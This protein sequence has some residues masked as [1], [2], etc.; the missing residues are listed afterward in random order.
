MKIPIIE[1]FISIQ[2]EGDNIGHLTYFI[3]FPHCDLSCIW[4]DTTYASK[5]SETEIKE[6]DVKEIV[7][8]IEK[9]VEKNN[10][11]KLLIT[12]TGGEP[13]L[14]KK[15]IENIRELLEEKDV[16]Y[17][18]EIE[19]NGTIM[20]LKEDLESPYAFYGENYYAYNISPKLSSSGNSSKKAIKIETL[21]YFNEYSECIFKFVIKTDEDWKQMEKIIKSVGINKEDVYIMPEG[22]TDSEL[23]KNTK[24]L[25][26]KII[27]NGYNFSPRIHIWLWGKKRGV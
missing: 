26:N 13:L 14:H 21:K 18:I 6:I 25:I 24:K 9:I 15:E 4:C 10:G 12:F 5:P 27:E 16:N 8:D 11:S 23:K 17:K 19:T 3:R 2:G 1:R 22:R 7:K 20:P